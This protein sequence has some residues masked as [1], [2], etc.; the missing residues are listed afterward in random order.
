[1]RIE[2]VMKVIFDNVSSIDG[3]TYIKIKKE[4]QSLIDKDTQ[5]DIENS[6]RNNPDRSGGQF[7]D[8]EINRYNEWN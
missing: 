3:A 5:K 1:M 6:W 2:E 7:T 8:E 4:I